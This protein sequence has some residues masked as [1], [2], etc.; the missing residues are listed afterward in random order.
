MAGGAMS[1]GWS[2]S[3]GA[4]SSPV[5]VWA[6]GA[7]LVVMIDRPSR[8]NAIDL[9]TAEAIASAMDQLDEDDALKAGVIT[10]AGGRFSAGMDLRAAAATG[11]RPIVLPRGFAGL[12]EQPPAKPLIAAVEGPAMGG[13]CEIALACDLVV[14]GSG[15]SFGLPEVRVGLVPGGG[16]LF[17]LPAQIPPRIATELVLTGDPIFAERAFELGLV[18]RV[19]PDGS[20]LDEA[21]DLARRMASAAPVAVRAALTVMRETTLSTSADW[22]ARQQPEVDRVRATEDAQEGPRAFAEKRAPVW[23]GR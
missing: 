6:D 19:V 12:V 5:R 22:W 9:P 11:E 7:V 21:L 17:R 14:A 1:E 16:G 20:A 18:N 23:V 4:A 15:A 2:S 3:T 8:A 10:G 13:G